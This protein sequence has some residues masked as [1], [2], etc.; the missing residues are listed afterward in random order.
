MNKAIIFTGKVSWEH[1]TLQSLKGRTAGSWLT[2][3]WAEHPHP[4]RFAAWVQGPAFCGLPG[5]TALSAF[6]RHYIPLQRSRN[7][8]LAA[9]LGP[10]RRWGRGTQRRVTG[11]ATT[12]DQADFWSLE[13]RTLAGKGSTG[14]PSWPNHL[15]RFC[16][17]I[18]WGHSKARIK[19]P[20]RNC[21][22]RL[23]RSLVTKGNT[24]SVKPEDPMRTRK[25]WIGPNDSPS[26]KR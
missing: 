21:L 2:W 6:P 11:S 3:T 22:L 4:G 12:N 9:P 8:R 24:Q 7:P 14:S 5:P 13:A 23:K 20:I 25:E 1:D 15:R 10:H 17:P 19:Y 16:P 26:I 18:G